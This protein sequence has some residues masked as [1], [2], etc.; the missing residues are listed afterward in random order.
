MAK[1]ISNKTLMMLLVASIALS[2][3]GTV[4]NVHRLDALSSMSPSITGFA[5]SGTGKINFT[6]ASI[7][8]ISVTDGVLDFGSC[9]PNTTGTYRICSNVYR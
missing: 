3:I 2:L 6:V 7:T 4:S 1:N 8:Q 5:T 9:S